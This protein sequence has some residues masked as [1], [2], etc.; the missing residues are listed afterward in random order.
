MVF[1]TNAV[2]LTMLAESEGADW[3]RKHPLIR[4]RFDPWSLWLVC[5]AV[6]ENTD[7]IT[8][9]SDCPLVSKAS[10]RHDTV[11]LCYSHMK[12]LI[13]NKVGIM[14]VV[15]LFNRSLVRSLIHSSIHVSVNNNLGPEVFTH[16]FCFLVFLSK[17]F[18]KKVWQ[19]SYILIFN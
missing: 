16:E 9:L 8:R 4:S 11:L 2:R 5:R 10:S 13:I 12:Y 7:D 15:Y 3:P 19:F 6:A 18:H 14:L 17:M 1:Y